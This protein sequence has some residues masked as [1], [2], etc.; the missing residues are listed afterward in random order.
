MELWTRKPE[1][2]QKLPNGGAL[3]RDR[4]C[5]WRL[6][7]SIRLPVLITSIRL[8]LY[9]K[10]FYCIAHDRWEHFYDSRLLK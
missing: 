9:H 7:P 6:R 8:Y 4:C 5:G 3:V 2:L 10:A 1:L